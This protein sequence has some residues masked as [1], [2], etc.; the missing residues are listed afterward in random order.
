MKILKWIAGVFASVAF[1]ILAFRMIRVW[2]E[3]ARA[4]IRDSEVKKNVRYANDHFEELV[5]TKL[6]E[7]A[8]AKSDEIEA[9]WKERFGVK[10]D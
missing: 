10:E 1:T 7:I 5:K 8:Q 6:I 2:Q 3:M 9:L 4:E